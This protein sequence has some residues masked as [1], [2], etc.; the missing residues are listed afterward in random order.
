MQTFSKNA[1]MP[2][3][4]RLPKYRK[5]LEELLEEGIMKVSSKE[6]S[7]RMGSTAS[8]IRQDLNYFG[9]FGQQGY[10]YNVSEL[11]DII[12]DILA[13]KRTYKSII[14][15]AGNLGRAI[16]NYITSLESGTEIKAIFDIDYNKA[17]T[18][19]NN[20]PVY[21]NSAL[22]EYTASH[23]IDIAILTVPKSSGLMA[24]KQVVQNGVKAIWN[25]S[26]VD[27]LLDI[28]EDI[29][30]ENVS[31]NESFYVLTYLLSERLDG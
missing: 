1:P 2:V 16:V 17:G 8:Q 11:I 4:R 24:A 25:F 28:E 29:V 22:K 5:Y 23:K 10:G 30:V 26:T 15:G 7:D 18:L 13:V 31:I 6:L 20:I 12:D 21:H 19:I 9:G 14:L 27:L 3:I